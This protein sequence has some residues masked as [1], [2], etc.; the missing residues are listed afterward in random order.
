MPLILV[1]LFPSLNCKPSIHQRTRGFPFSWWSNLIL[2]LL[3][4]LSCSVMFDSLR[5]HGLQHA[6]LPC[7]SPTPPLSRWWHPTLSP[8]VVP[9]S[10]CTQSFPASG[11]FAMSQLFASGGQSISF[12]LSPSNEYS[13]PIS[14]RMDWFDLLVLQGTLKNLPQHHA[15][16]TSILRHSAFFFFTFLFIY[17]FFPYIFLIKKITNY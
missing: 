11:S 10:S 17:L 15:S 9:F 4:L 5:P 6:R 7:P 13:G 2:P 3:W 16:T 14:F 8:S 1:C 12:N